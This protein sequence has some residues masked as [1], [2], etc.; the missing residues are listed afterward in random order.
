[1]GRMLVPQRRETGRRTVGIVREQARDDGMDEH[2]VAP[3]DEEVELVQ[4]GR[5]LR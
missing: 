5:L 4:L 2:R 3:V 1:M